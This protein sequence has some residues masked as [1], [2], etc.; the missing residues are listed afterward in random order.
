IY[1]LKYSNEAEIEWRRV[2][3]ALAINETYF[4]RE[5]H[6]IDTVVTV[7]APE[8]M[9]RKMGQPLRIWHA[10]CA[11]GEEVYSMAIALKEAGLFDAG[12]IE[13]IA[14]DMNAAAIALA[15]RAI[16][17]Q[18][19]LRNLPPPVLEKYFQPSLQGEYT[20]SSGIR[21]LV[22][23]S[24]G[25]L[26]DP[27]EVQLIPPC[28]IIFC[29]NVFIYFSGDTVLQVATSFYNKLNEPGYLFLGAAESLFRFDTPFKFCEVND[30]F[31]YLREKSDGDSRSKET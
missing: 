6:A 17:R 20:L 1:L 23:F 9:R 28:D 14:T 26:V 7:L 31:C 2:E 3:T 25:N 4:W 5:F 24:R 19:S 11:T 29:R 12:P 16:Y 27:N 15:R 8:L 21:S 10:G 13:L 30:S 18:R 22:Q